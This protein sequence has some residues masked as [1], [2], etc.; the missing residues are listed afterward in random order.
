MYTVLTFS[1]ISETPMRW[2]VRDDG[3]Q[4]AINSISERA[5][6]VRCA[7]LNAIWEPKRCGNT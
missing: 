6:R 7:L 5:E 3:N 1:L 2:D 4:D